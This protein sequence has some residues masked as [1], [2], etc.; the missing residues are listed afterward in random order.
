MESENIVFFVTTL[1]SGGLENYLLRF[2]QEKHEAFSQIYI[3]C[4]GG[5]AGQLER[6]YLS[7]SN[8]SIIKHKVGYFNLNA[9]EKIKFFLLKNKI[10]I[11]CDFTG[12]FSGFILKA[13]FKANV[14]K[15]VAFYRSSSNRFKNN[16]FRNIY[17]RF[18]KYLVVM[19]STNILS[20]SIAAFDYFH[21]HRWKKDNRFDVVYNG[22]NPLSFLNEKDDLRNEFYI[23]DAAFVIGHTGRF[24]EAKNHKT[25]LLVAEK[26]LNKHKDIYF[27][28]CG[29]GVKLNL[30]S[31]FE[32]KEIKNRILFFENREDI[33]KFLNTMDCYF[34]PSVTEGQPN[35]LI[36]AMVMGL[37]YVASN[38]DSIKETANSLDFLFSPYDV[39]S[40]YTALNNMYFSKQKKDFKLQAATIK[41]YCY[42]KNFG[43][44]YDKLTK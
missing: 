24:N 30:N 5:K 7:L 44:F 41:K 22:I 15:R 2:L 3:Y 42:K 6:E 33:P 26:L 13:A 43:L 21:P 39:E 23:P 20:N 12:N 17:N 1:D 18:V 4:K 34:F 40:F 14:N 8:V 28:L 9:Y 31:S 27:I 29:N 16:I 32:G 19:Y 35:A 11:V 25:I 38:I 36:E 10:S 37:P